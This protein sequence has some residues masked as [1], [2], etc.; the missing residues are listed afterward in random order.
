MVGGQIKKV[1]RKSDK[2]LDKSSRL[3][4]HI[5]MDEKTP[6]SERKS[7]MPNRNGEPWTECEE[8][9]MVHMREDN[10]PFAEIARVLERSVGSVKVCF[11]RKDEKSSSQESKKKNHKRSSWTE[12][13]VTRLRKYR[14]EGRSL[15]SI[16]KV[17]GRTRRAIAAK[18][19]RDPE[20]DSKKNSWT[21]EDNRV[22]FRMRSLGFTHKEIA[23]V[24]DRTSAA[25][26]T[27]FGLINRKEDLL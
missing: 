23:K 22:L 17:L 16:A 5:R 14:E 26:R 25:V 11:Y 27:Q 20:I 8:R 18:V 10:Y 1:V 2:I 9:F 21:R 24:L 4:Y 12:K 15:K 13:E 19:S 3:S 6:E 7:S